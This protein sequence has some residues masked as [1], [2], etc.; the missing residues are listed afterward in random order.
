MTAPQA[1]AP[2]AADGTDWKA[3]A[4]KWK[5]LSRKNETQAKGNVDE[6]TRNSAALKAIAD[7]LGVDIGDGTPDPARLTAELD[8][9]NTTARQRAAELAVYKAATAAG[10]NADLLLDSRAFMASID[11]LDPS[12]DGYAASVA[13][14]AKAWAEG[15]PQVK[16]EQA[17]PR[18]ATPPTPR[19]GADFGAPAPN[20]QWT[21]ADLEASTPEQLTKA[22][23][24][25]LLRDLGIGT[26]RR[27]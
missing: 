15:H 21:Q 17:T 8:K 12:A 22:L 27:R 7:K 24:A 18:K 11:G 6:L 16:T 3:E 10:A 23:D 14:A 13:D 4:E 1:T 2:A 25:G 26:R 19:A 20:R 9:A 5:A